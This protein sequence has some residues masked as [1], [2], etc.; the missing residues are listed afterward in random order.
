MKKTTGTALAVI[1]ALT[2]L[3]AGCGSR[4]EVTVREDAGFNG[5]SPMEYRKAEETAFTY[6]SDTGF[7][8]NA[9]AADQAAS[10]KAELTAESGRKLIKTMAF[11]IETQEFDRSTAVISAL[12]ARLGGYVED[13]SVSGSSISRNESRTAKYVLRIPVSSLAEFD[14]N[15]SDIG[16]IT[17]RSENVKD[18]TLAYTDTASRLKSLETQR[19]TLIELMSRAE[20]LEDMLTIQDHLTGVEYELERYASQLRLYDNQVEYSSVSI[21]LS[22]VRTYTEPQ[23]VPVTFGERISAAF[24]RGLQ[25]VG[26]F[27]KDLVLYLAEHV[28]GFVLIAAVI[29]TVVMLVKRIIKKQRAGKAAACAAQRAQSVQKEQSGNRPGEPN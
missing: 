27:F 1:A 9:P 8:Q 28:F 23:E 10:E 26:N 16:N 20:S 14:S 29:G 13:A 3:L 12:V 7:S 6:T 25:S 22:E 18:I 11:S 15:V 21:T 19:D 2:L 17:K 24:K 5:N 4:K